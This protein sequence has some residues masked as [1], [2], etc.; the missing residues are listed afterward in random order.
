MA[1][2]P[3]PAATKNIPGPSGFSGGKGWGKRE[4]PGLKTIDSNNMPCCHRPPSL[5]NHDRC[6]TSACIFAHQPSGWLKDGCSSDCLIV[7][8][9]PL[10]E[11]FHLSQAHSNCTL[12]VLIYRILTLTPW[13][14]FFSYLFKDKTN[15]LRSEVTCPMLH[16]SKW[17]CWVLNPGIPVLVS[18]F[19][20]GG[21]SCLPLAVQWLFE[22]HLDGPTCHGGEVAA[23][24]IEAHTRRTLETYGKWFR[25]KL[26][27]I[28]L[29]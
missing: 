8:G 3:Q 21:G 17:Q 18:V 22:A 10:P 7:W 23:H 2:T 4:E 24:K 11:I 13:G 15:T 9:S 19:V 28:F 1:S 26:L 12:H 27:D 6:P 5:H 16:S 29:F 25:R 20:P 14:S